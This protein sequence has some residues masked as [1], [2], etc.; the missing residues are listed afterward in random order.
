MDF[1]SVIRILGGGAL[2]LIVVCL[3]FLLWRIWQL[4]KT[5]EV[6]GMVTMLFRV[7]VAGLNYMLWA[8]FGS[9]AGLFF[10]TIQAYVTVRIIWWFFVVV[11]LLGAIVY[12]IMCITIELYRDRRRAE[13]DSQHG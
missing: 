9:I 6:N 10:G 8:A 2:W 12:A 5:G 4:K 13:V 11:W 1:L 3:T 7:L